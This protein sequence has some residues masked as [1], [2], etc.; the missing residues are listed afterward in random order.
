VPWL[1]VKPVM[2]DYITVWCIIGSVIHSNFLS[3]FANNNH[4]VS[5]SSRRQERLECSVNLVVCNQQMY[6]T[7]MTEAEADMQYTTAKLLDTETYKLNTYSRQHIVI[8]NEKH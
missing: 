8:K 5:P 6:I 3:Y 2:S 4:G 1:Q 7:I